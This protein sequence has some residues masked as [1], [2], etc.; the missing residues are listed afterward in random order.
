MV[1]L[2]HQKVLF[3]KLKNTLN[4]YIHKDTTKTTNHQIFK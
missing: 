1:T 2:Y 4:P 3:V